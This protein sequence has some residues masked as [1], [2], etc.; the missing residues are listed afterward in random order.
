[1]T[2]II[3]NISKLIII[4]ILLITPNLNSAKEILIYADDISY[5]EEENIVARGNAKIFQDDQLIISELIIYN[6]KDNI[7]KL[8]TEFSF[9]DKNNNFFN[10]SNGYF[11]QNL[12]YGEFEN[13]KI[14]LNDGSRIIGTR[15]KRDGDVDIISKGVY[16][17]CN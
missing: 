4:F 8:P 9:K 15:G 1:M 5:D 3:L 10:A 7:I 2:K 16:S 13:I 17:P 14:R 6:K 12:E 11:K